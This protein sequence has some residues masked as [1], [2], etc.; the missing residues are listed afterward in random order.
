MKYDLESRLILKTDV[1]LNIKNKNVILTSKNNALLP[2]YLNPLIALLFIMH[3]NGENTVKDIAI[4]IKDTMDIPLNEAEKR[5]L[6]IINNL[7]PYLCEAVF[8]EN[9]EV[10]IIN[11]EVD[12]SILINKLLYLSEKKVDFS[13]ILNKAPSRLSIN[14]TDVCARKC[15]YCSTGSKYGNVQNQNNNF[16]SVERFAQIL[17]EAKELGVTFIEIG[18]GDPFMCGNIFKYIDILSKTN[19]PWM[20]STKMLITEDMAM[21]LKKLNVSILQVSLDTYDEK[22]AD[23]LM[24]VKGSFSQII[25]SVTNLQKY[26]INVRVKGV[27]TSYNIEQIPIFCLFL[28]E[29]G[30]KNISFNFYGASCGRNKEELYPTFNQINNLN[31]KM[32]KLINN[33]KNNIEIDYSGENLINHLDYIYGSVQKK[34]I[35]RR[36]CGA[37]VS[38]LNIRP[39]G[40][41]VYCD[42]LQNDDRFIIGD[43]KSQ[44]IMEIW[45]SETL[46]SWKIPNR[47]YFKNT[48]CYDCKLFNKCYTKRCFLRSTIQY[49]TPFEKDPWCPYAD[50]DYIQY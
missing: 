36:Q 34:N 49:G 41:V 13:V 47:E 6:K 21:K 45:N 4:I 42:S 12:N 9:K 16:L 40:K 30:I 50:T 22:T 10:D 2:M 43:L 44:S 7:N 25:S 17:N 19:I 1:S 33:V 39:D 26:K 31:S 8:N 14:I 37:S 20:L 35:N 23:F 5:T 27:I 38:Q 11:R 24:D 48:D 32:K 29:K 3:L 15:I 28:I 18:G 46:R